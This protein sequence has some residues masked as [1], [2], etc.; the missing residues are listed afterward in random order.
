VGMRVIELHMAH[1]YLGCEFLSPLSNHRS[2]NY[3]GPLE[4]RARFPLEV[5]RAVRKEMPDSMP[6]LV[7]VSGTEYMKGGW[8]I[9]E[10][11]ELA[12]WF[13]EEGGDMIDCSSGGNSPTKPSRLSRAIRSSSPLGSGKKLISRQQRSD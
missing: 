12:K 8:D 4:N 5:V 7:R 3:G 11:V 13:K 2:D 10:C 9:D 6:L 1:G